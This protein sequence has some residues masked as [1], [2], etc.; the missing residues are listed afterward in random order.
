MRVSCIS[1]CQEYQTSV[2]TGDGGVMT[3]ALLKC[4]NRKTVKALRKKRAVSVQYVFNRM[5]EFT[6]EEEDDEDDEG[7]E[8]WDSEEYEDYDDDSEEYEY[9][10][11]EDDD[12][13]D[14]QN[15]NLSWPGGC[16][17]SRVAFPF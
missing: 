14:G 1:G 2:D 12:E 4:I 10:E 16:D 6:A 15:I 9:S 17:P 13:D 3:N 7:D 11:F 5:V 8:E